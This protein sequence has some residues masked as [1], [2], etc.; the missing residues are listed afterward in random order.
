MEEEGVEGVEDEKSINICYIHVP[1]HL[2]KC[3]HYALQA[4]S[5]TNKNFKNE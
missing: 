4:Y 3:N 2:D 1:A 5:N